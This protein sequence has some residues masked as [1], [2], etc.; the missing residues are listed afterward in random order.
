MNP[1]QPGTDDL[2][3]AAE[4]ALAEAWDRPLQLRLIEAIGDTAML[5]RCAVSPV[6]SQQETVVV[7]L[8]TTTAFTSAAPGE[9]SPRLLNEWISLE[10]LETRGR[11]GPRVLGSDPLRGLLVLEDLGPA[12][13][14]IDLLLRR[15]A[16]TLHAPPSRW[17]DSLVASRW[18]APAKSLCFALGSEPDECRP[19]VRIRRST[20]ALAATHWPARAMISGSIHLKRFGQSSSNSNV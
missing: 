3:T 6:A 1:N 13:R 2:L 11:F 9:T 12:P 10:F 5:L 18:R 15:Q 8:V 4:R 7:K 16:Q 20:C 17:V 19:R 14:V